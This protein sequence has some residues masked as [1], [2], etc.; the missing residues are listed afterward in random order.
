VVGNFEQA[1][2]GPFEVTHVPVEALAAQYDAAADPMQ[3]SFCGG[4][5]G[6]P[7]G[8]TIDMQRTLKAFPSRLTSVEQQAR[9]VRP[10]A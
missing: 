10:A 3:K 6:Y 7:D 5:L 8:F 4:M 2:G 1:A 9:R